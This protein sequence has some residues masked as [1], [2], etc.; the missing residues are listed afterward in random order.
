MKASSYKTLENKSIVN[1][2][3]PHVIKRM[4]FAASLNSG[5][6]HKGQIIGLSSGALAVAS[7]TVGSEVPAYGVILETVDTTAA[8]FVNVLVHGTVNK[9]E[10]LGYAG[11]AAA[12]ATELAG[13]EKAGIWAI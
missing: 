8:G 11:S 1:G 7:D 5:K 3:H 12:T 2:I 9:D 4:A 6:L 10:I 13:L